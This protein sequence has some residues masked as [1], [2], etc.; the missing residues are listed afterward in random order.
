[1]RNASNNWG[2]NVTIRMP[3]GILLLAAAKNAN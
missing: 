3:V 2:G 1:M